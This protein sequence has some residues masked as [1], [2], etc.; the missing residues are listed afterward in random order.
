MRIMK[1][2]PVYCLGLLMLSTAQAKVSEFQLDNGLKLIVREDHRAP[3]M[4]S[5]VWYKVGSSYEQN[6]ITGV[7]HV[8]EH[9]MFKGTDKLKPGEFSRIIAANGG[10]EN[11]F[12]SRDYTAYFQSMEKSRLS[13]SFELEADRM[14]GLVLTDE[15]FK[16]E[17]KV[18]MEERR[19]RTEDKP[20]SYTYEQYNAVASLTSP[21][22][23]PII[24]W[25]KD[26]ESMTVEDLK[27][28][29]RLWYAP[30]NATVVVAGD[31]DAQAVYALAKKYF[32][33]LK[34]SKNLLPPKP[35]TEPEQKG[36]RRIQVKMPAQLPYLLMG[37]PV[38][39]LKTAEQEWEAYALEVLA[40][41]L[42]G[43]DSARLPTRLVRQQGLLTSAG[44]GY[45]LGS[46]LSGQFLLEGVPAQ[47][48]S[49][50]QAEAALLKEVKQLREKPVDKDELER[51]KAQVVASNV[52][53]RDSVFYQ[54][55]QTGVYETVGL[56]WKRLD[57][58]VEKIQSITPEQVQ[59]VAVKYLV[60]DRLS[61]AEMVPLPMDQKTVSKKATGD[62]HGS[63]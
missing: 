10:R 58:Y 46:R 50:Q 41:V 31:V 12:T 20:E 24:G 53:E 23:T 60:D 15:E 39:S 27:E 7:S 47:G 4:V 11:A 3:V 44:A 21:Y 26:L 36:Q 54:A 32:G 18:V 5:Q 17:V 2:L 16:K 55:M 34:P 38:P 14:R 35:Q 28:W 30:N 25:M 57:D 59:A 49:I 13:V 19:L 62:H 29:Y 9:M 56:G 63:H 8:L 37:Y 45:T 33:P 48:Y 43:G 22:R 42:D 40:G 6:G 1:S 51:I 61:I 52:F